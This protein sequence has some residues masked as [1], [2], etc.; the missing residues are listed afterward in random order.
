MDANKHTYD[1]NLKFSRLS[2]PINSVFLVFIEDCLLY[3]GVPSG[4][5]WILSS[6]KMYIFAKKKF[7]QNMN[8]LKTVKFL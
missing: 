8:R 2:R 7:V 3:V 6:R 4:Q 1:Q 5:L